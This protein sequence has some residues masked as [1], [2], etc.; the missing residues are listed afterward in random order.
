MCG[1]T[2]Q[3]ALEYPEDVLF[4]LD[5]VGDNCKRFLSVANRIGDDC[6]HKVFDAS[7][8]QFPKGFSPFKEISDYRDT[9][10]HDAV[11]GRGVGIG[12]IYI[13]KWNIDKFTSPLERARRSWR[14]AERL[15]AANL[16]STKDL[17]ERLINETCCTL[18]LLWQQG[19]RSVTSTAFQTK[20]SQVTRLV[21]HFPLKVQ[22]PPPEGVPAASGVFVSVGSN[23]NFVVPTAPRSGPDADFL[24][25]TLG[26][27]Q[28]S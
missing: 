1:S 14:D 16:V 24:G 2:E 5:S 13:P 15:P 20:M 4:L 23:T 28:R 10:L 26:G 12:K 25:D 11:M 3:T 19:I 9:L 7:V 18:E 21:G 22:P 17:L 27:L 8:A 6:G